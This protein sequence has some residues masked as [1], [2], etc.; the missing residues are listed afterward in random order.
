MKKFRVLL[1]II[2]AIYAFTGCSKQK[3]QTGMQNADSV[4]IFYGVTSYAMFSSDEN[5]IKTLSGYFNNL[6]FEPT[7]KKM[8]ITT[9]LSV[10]FFTGEKQIEKFSIDKNSVFWLNGDIEC[11]KIASG[12]FNYDAVKEIYEKSKKN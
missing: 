1:V 9:M 3:V 10:V 5:T 2:L 6:S 7:D 8:D 4:T 11:F 12:T